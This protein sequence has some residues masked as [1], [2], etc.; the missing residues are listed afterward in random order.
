MWVGVFFSG[1]RRHTRWPRDWSSD[2]CSSDLEPGGTAGDVNLRTVVGEFYGPVGKRFRYLGEKAPE[3][4]NDP[5]GFHLSADPGACGDLVV[6]RGEIERSIVGGFDPDPRKYGDGGPVRESARRPRHSVCQDVTINAELHS[7][8]LSLSGR[9]VIAIRLYED[10]EKMRQRVG[11]CVSVADA[12]TTVA[13]LRGSRAL[14]Q[15]ARK[16]SPSPV[17]R[18]P[19]VGVTRKVMYL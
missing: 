14:N 10:N 18:A 12:Q 2:V 9:F 4:E 6:E 7:A 17:P 8:G 19:I 13:A 15:A 16:S 11:T 3:N 1:R 5:G